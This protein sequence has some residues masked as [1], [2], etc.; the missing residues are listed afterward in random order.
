MVVHMQNTF[1]GKASTVHSKMIG[2]D[3]GISVDW[4]FNRSRGKGGQRQSGCCHLLL[5]MFEKF[6]EM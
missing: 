6:R 4:L 5:P 1:E 3:T 2:Q